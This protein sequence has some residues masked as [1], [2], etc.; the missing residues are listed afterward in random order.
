MFDPKNHALAKL[1]AS[2]TGE[3]SKHSLFQRLPAMT[4][5]SGVFKNWAES[6]DPIL[7]PGN[8][9]AWI[10][11]GKVTSHEKII[12]DQLA[13]LRW[14]Y[15]TFTL[16]Y[17]VKQ[18]KDAGHIRRQRGIG[19]AGASELVFL[20]WKG[21]FPKGMAKTRLYVDKGSSTYVDYMMK[22]PV[23]TASELMLVPK[24]V[25]EDTLT[26]SHCSVSEPSGD[27]SSGGPA[28][29][30]TMTPRARY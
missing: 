30:A 3:G 24:V 28:V 10:F 16:L 14:E 22:V 21:S 4:P 5:E 13:K 27:N 18:M 6:I 12:R 7:S 25:C 1:Y 2:T 20:A 15:K 19:N 29:T 23:A 11:S 8:D 17:D 26:W 9:F